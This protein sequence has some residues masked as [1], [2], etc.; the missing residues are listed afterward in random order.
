MIQ[1]IQTLWLAITAVVALLTIKFSVFSGNMID[2]TGLRKW[3]ELNAATNFFIL[4]LTIGVAVTAGIVIFLYRDRK[5]QL[6]LSIIAL[7]ISLINLILYYNEV[8]KFSPE[9]NYDLTCLLALSIPVFLVLA[10]MGIYKD[11]KLIRS[12]D[13]LR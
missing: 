7:I 9:G 12:A 10:I 11:E 8:R 13:R 2:S 3:V 1:R 5:I 6:R 4:I